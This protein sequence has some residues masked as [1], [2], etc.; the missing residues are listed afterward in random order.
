MSGFIQSLEAAT[1][2]FVKRVLFARSNAYPLRKVLTFPKHTTDF[3]FSV[4]YSDFDYLVPVEQSYAASGLH[5]K[6]G[7]AGVTDA[8]AKHVDKRAKGVKTHFRVDSSGLF[9]LEQAEAIFEHEKE[10]EVPSTIEST[11]W[12]GSFRISPINRLKKLI[13]QNQSINQSID[14]SIEKS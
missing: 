14:C 3:D 9:F 7:L 10:E 12:H 5:F 11:C 6:I 1:A 4:R 8:F 13:E 2:K